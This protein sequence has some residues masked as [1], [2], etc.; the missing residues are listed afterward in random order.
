MSGKIYRPHV[1]EHHE[2]Q[3]K[4]TLVDGG[5]QLLR[6]LALFGSFGPDAHPTVIILH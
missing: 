2:I 5:V 4:R 3:P 1:D 6:L